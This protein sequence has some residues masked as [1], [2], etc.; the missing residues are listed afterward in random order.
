MSMRR[1]FA[2]YRSTFKNSFFFDNVVTVDSE[3]M[4]RSSFRGTY[5]PK[6]GRKSSAPGT[7]YRI[8]DVRSPST[9]YPDGGPENLM[10]SGKEYMSKKHSGGP[11]IHKHST[12]IPGHKHS[13]IASV[14]K[15]SVTFKNSMLY[16][17]SDN[18]IR[19][20][21]EK[22]G[23][24]SYDDACFGIH[25]VSGTVSRKITQSSTREFT[26]YPQKGET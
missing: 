21:W 4:L 3:G 11:S 5:I 24:T 25:T 20:I 1:S 26:R 17:K 12:I 7:Q 15:N 19:N 18:F 13:T 10:Y 23:S 8:N 22:C 2:G 14:H 16:V 6:N 9:Y